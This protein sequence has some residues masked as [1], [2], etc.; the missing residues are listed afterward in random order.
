MILTATF[1]IALCASGQ[2]DTAYKQRVERVV[3]E[4]SNNFKGFIGN[5]HNTGLPK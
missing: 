1:F 4:Y 3:K 2:S 5:A